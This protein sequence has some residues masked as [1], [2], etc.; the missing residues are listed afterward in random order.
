MYRAPKLHLI[1]IQIEAYKSCDRTLALA[2]VQSY[3]I[4][5]QKVH[6]YLHLH[7]YNIMYI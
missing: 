2:I 6:L 4:M 1:K 3:R 5:G 7:H